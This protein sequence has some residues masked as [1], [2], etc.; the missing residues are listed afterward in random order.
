MSFAA[1]AANHAVKVGGS[2][3]I[4]TP[5]SLTI[6]A[7]DTVTFTNAGGFHNVV[8]DDGSFR[9]ADNCTGTGGNANSS[10]WSSQ[11]VYNTAGTFGYYCEIHGGPGAGMHGSIT[12][13]AAPPP[14]PPPAP[15]TIGGYLSGNWYNQ[16]QS[17][18]G[19][20]LEVT[21]NANQM[22]AIWFVFAPG[23][24]SQWIYAQGTYDPTSSTI[25]MP[26]AL[27]QNGKFP[28]PASNYVASD[29]QKAAWGTLTFTFSDCNTG[30]ASWNSTVT[31][32]G[33][34]SIPITRLTQIAGTVCP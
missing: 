19:F 16:T 23:G 3:L 11:V 27:V 7:G 12:V 5:A 21:S 9:C 33:S 22:V 24:G 17:G 30:V 15:T 13:E 32:Y 6:A 18:S 2:G 25:T 8:A 31:G 34:G 1:F 14:P 28:F 26:A 20:Q 4:F 10:A 29:I